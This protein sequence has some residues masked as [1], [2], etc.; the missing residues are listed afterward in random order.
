MHIK[1]PAIVINI[2]FDVIKSKKQKKKNKINMNL[3]R[4]SP[5]MFFNFFL[6]K[7]VS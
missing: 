4:Q 1:L 3:E 6:T 2:G 7:D 5:N